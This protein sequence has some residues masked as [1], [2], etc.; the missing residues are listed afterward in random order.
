MHCNSSFFS[1]QMAIVSIAKFL[2]LI[3]LMNAV[4]ISMQFLKFIRY[5]NVPNQ[6]LSN[7]RKV[8][9]RL[10]PPTKMKIDTLQILL[11]TT[12]YGV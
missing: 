6:E 11:T 9:R 3:L 4:L 7:T 12:T 8:F 2:L 5:E 10:A 1:T